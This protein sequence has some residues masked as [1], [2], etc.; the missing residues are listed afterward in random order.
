MEK[1]QEVCELKKHQ[2]VTAAT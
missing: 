1:V 2:I